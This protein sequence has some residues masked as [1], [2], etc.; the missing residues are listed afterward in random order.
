MMGE[1]LGSFFRQRVSDDER[2][3][4]ICEASQRSLKPFLVIVCTPGEGRGITDA[5]RADPRL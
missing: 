3:V 1:L 2:L 4:V 5:I